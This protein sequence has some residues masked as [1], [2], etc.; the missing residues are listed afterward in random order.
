MFFIP[1]TVETAYFNKQ[2]HQA[3]SE[4]RKNRESTAIIHYE[5][6]IGEAIWLLEHHI[7]KRETESAR[8]LHQT[9]KCLSKELKAL[10]LETANKLASE[11]II[12]SC[13]AMRA[14][15][16]LVTKPP[17]LPQSLYFLLGF[18]RHFHCWALS[19][20]K[21]YFSHKTQHIKAKI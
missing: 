16:M 1:A 3:R 18:G 9:I 4:V 20:S 8:A 14:A 17:Q 10:Q 13:S 7:E 11:A 6:A 21:L 5:R 12:D 2:V 19:K 15:H